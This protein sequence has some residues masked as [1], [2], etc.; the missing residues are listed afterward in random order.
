MRDTW[1]ARLAE[2]VST[3]LDA[4]MPA[5][6]V[7]CGRAGAAFC[8]ACIAAI[9]PV[10]PP[11]CDWCGRSLGTTP[12][13]SPPIPRATCDGC[14]GARPATPKTRSAGTFD[15]VLRT[16]IHAFKYRDRPDAARALASLLEAPAREVLGG[17]SGIIVPV[18]LHPARTGERG[19][20]QSAL[21]SRHLADATGR[22]WADAVARARA[23]PAQVGLGRAARLANVAGAFQALRRLDRQ[24]VLL[25]DDV[26]TTGATLADAARACRVAGATEVVAVTLANDQSVGRP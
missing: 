25:V 21:L 12:A 6:C 2:G 18:A 1:W 5:P 22:D 13:R 19:Y 7:A 17:A 20:D 14:V 4:L 15:G 8:E 16:A 9:P 11:G 26:T 24:V 3:V 23:T 10:P